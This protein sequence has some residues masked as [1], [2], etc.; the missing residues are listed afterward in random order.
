MNALVTEL[1]EIKQDIRKFYDAFRIVWL[2]D[3]KGYGF[4]V[5]DVRIG[6]LLSRID[7]VTIVLTD[8][9]EGRLEKIYELEEKRLEYFDERLSG[10]ESYAPIHGFWATAYT[11]NHI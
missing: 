9:L 4:E 3:Y 6:G 1:Q 2:R 7:T 8:Y 11:V 10:E 5:M